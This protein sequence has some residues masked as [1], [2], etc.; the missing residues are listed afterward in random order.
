[1]LV[2]GVV[3]D[4]VRDQLEAALVHGRQQPV[5]VGQ[6]AEARVD[7]L[8]VADVVAAVVPRRPVDRRQPDH[9]DAELDQVVQLRLDPGQ[10]A[11]AVPVRV[12]EA[13]RIDL[14]DD[15]ALPPRLGHAHRP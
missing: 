9:V 5:E 15:G 11:D 14:V 7:V 8:V 12:G 13:A 2:R 6:R 1:V 4:Q 10:V 3:D